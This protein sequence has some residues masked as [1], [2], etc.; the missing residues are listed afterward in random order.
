[1]SLKKLLLTCLAMASFVVAH[2][3]EASHTLVDHSTDSAD[4][5]SADESIST[6]KSA[7][8]TVQAQNAALLIDRLNNQFRDPRAGYTFS[9]VKTPERDLYGV[10]IVHGKE[11][12]NHELFYVVVEREQCLVRSVELRDP[13]RDEVQK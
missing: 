4:E 6:S 11:M 1:M 2:A 13:F 3:E 10:V 9:E 8:C 12:S 5:A 7:K